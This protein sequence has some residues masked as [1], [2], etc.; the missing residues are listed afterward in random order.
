MGSLQN[1]ESGE[2]KVAYTDKNCLSFDDCL[3]FTGYFVHQYFKKYSEMF[4]SAQKGHRYVVIQSAYMK[5]LC[6]LLLPLP[7]NLAYA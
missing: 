5:S 6:L 4:I 2:Q 1:G 3:N 7:C